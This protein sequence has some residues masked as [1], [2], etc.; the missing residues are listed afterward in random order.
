MI[1]QGS[2]ASSPSGHV[3]IDDMFL[4]GSGAVSIAHG[5]TPSRVGI[6]AAS[7][8]TIAY[9]LTGRAISRTVLASQA[10]RLYLLKRADGM[11]AKQ[12]TTVR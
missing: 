4:V 1:V 7:G 3:Y 8:R 5:M 6:A 9:D 10:T 12:L 11:V 2:S